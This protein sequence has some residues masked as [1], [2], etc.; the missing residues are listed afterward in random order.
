[1]KLSKQQ[2]SDLTNL[3]MYEEGMREDTKLKLKEYFVWD[4][5]TIDEK[6]EVIRDYLLEHK[7]KLKTVYL[8]K[9]G[10]C[11]HKDPFCTGN[12]KDGTLCVCNIC[13]KKIKD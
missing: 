9:K 11:T 7:H 13:N 5:L 12:H 6:L 4:Q 10:F 1:M 8:V 3:G 2:K